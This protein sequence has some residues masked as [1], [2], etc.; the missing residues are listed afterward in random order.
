MFRRSMFRR[1]ISSV[2]AH[3]LILGFV[4]AC[5]IVSTA[6][7]HGGASTSGGYGLG[8]IR[9]PDGVSTKDDL[10]DFHEAMAV[11]ATG[12]QI[13]E[14]EALVKTTEAA[15]SAL[16]ALLQP[17][18][19][20]DAGEFSRRD[21]VLDQM[22]GKARTDGKKF[23]DEF[24][25]EQKNGLKEFTKRLAKADS[26]V[27]SEVSKLDQTIQV[28]K[29]GPEVATR[30]QTLDKALADFSTQQLALGREMGIILANGQDLTFALPQVSTPVM[31]GSRTIPVAVAGELSQTAAENGQRTFK[32]TRIADLSELQQNITEL[33]SAQLN[34]SQMCG[35][36]VAIKQ[37]RLTPSAPASLLVM[38]LHFERWTCSR[39]AGQQSA[40]ELAED[41]GTVEVKL[42]PGIDKSELKLASEFGHI[43]ATA[44]LADSLRSGSLGE[45]L[46]D[47]ITQL[48]LT[49]MRAGADFKTLPPAVQNSATIQTAR[50]V[51]AGAGVLRVAL[52]GQVQISNEQA[53]QLASQLNQALSAQGP[54][55]R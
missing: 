39:I 17:E 43:D 15:K 22:L 26:D 30:A 27:A 45:D 14:F 6:Q 24:S 42:T 4:V 35:E 11:Q 25:A 13:T 18:G 2:A 44:M 21:A 47:K 36:R 19:K 28:A 40:N 8:G 53:D 16:Q 34:S 3:A 55:P 5:P 51:D 49:A 9:R 50:F 38:R 37:A 33:L 29:T 23:V 12:P 41:D 20:D 54:T 31:I 48:L 52:G 10:K 46:R 1:G 7:H 32:L